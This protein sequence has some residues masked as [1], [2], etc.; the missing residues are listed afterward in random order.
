M[1]LTPS[2]KSNEPFLSLI[3]SSF[4]SC[5]FAYAKF[6]LDRIASSIGNQ[7]Q[8]VSDNREVRST[9]KKYK[10]LNLKIKKFQ[11]I[12]TYLAKCFLYCVCLRKF[13]TIFLKQR[14][15]KPHKI[16][17][18]I[19]RYLISQ[20]HCRVW[21]HVMKRLSV[22]CTHPTMAVE[23]YKHIFPPLL[24]RFRIF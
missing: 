5:L 16:W 4:S 1:H 15:I 23:W 14:Y 2:L 19:S 8:V 3:S 24:K 13:K 18:I 6:T 17:L 11:H 9:K 12:P 22:A 21:R 10:S 20:V 7:W